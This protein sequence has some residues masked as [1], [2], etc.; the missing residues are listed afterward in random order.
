MYLVEWV[1][2]FIKSH[3][4]RFVLACCQDKCN[5]FILQPAILVDC[6]IDSSFGKLGDK[7]ENVWLP[8]NF[9]L[10]DLML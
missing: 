7:Y 3:M 9:P 2:S 5:Q 8:R 6:Y 4:P 10:Y 1:K